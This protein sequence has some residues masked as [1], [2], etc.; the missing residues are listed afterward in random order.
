M[1]RQEAHWL[2][3]RVG[4]LRHACDLDLL[5][6]FVRHPRSLLTSEQLAAFVGCELPQ[7]SASLDVLINA[8]LLTR[9]QNPTHAARLYVFRPDTTDHEW[10]PSFI[11]HASTRAG[12]IALKE[13]LGRQSAEASNREKRPVD[14]V[15][16]VTRARIAR[17]A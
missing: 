13:A 6:F 11:Q 5:I 7:L 9:T 8:G 15:T 17:N 3:A 16:R 12:R 2:I 10:L 1:E 4:V 14:L